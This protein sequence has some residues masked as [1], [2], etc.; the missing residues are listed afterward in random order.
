MLI[1]PMKEI[2]FYY[3]ILCLSGESNT[4]YCVVM[5]R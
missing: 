1:N 5:V 2:V 3:K 4:R